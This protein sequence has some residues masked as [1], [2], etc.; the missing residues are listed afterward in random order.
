MQ[1]GDFWLSRAPHQGSAGQAGLSSLNRGGAGSHSAAFACSECDRDLRLNSNF[2]L[3]FT[4][5]LDPSVDFLPWLHLW[6]FAK[7]GCP[8]YYPQLLIPDCHP[9]SCFWPLRRPWKGSSS[10]FY[11]AWNSQS[12]SNSCRCGSCTGPGHHQR[13]Q[14]TDSLKRACPLDCHTKVQLVFYA[15]VVY[16]L[17]INFRVTQNFR[18]MHINVHSPS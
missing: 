5:L 11:L 2:H 7:L 6:F 8:N 15:W 4:Y 17:Q 10:P 14:I 12:H 13:P 16:I 9:S 1:V 18:M 3:N